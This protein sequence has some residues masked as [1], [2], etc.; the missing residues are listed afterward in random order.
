ME[1][2]DSGRIPKALSPL[3][4]FG[5]E[6]MPSFGHEGL[7]WSHCTSHLSDYIYISWW[8]ITGLIS[9]SPSRCVCFSL[10]VCATDLG[11][12]SSLFADIPQPQ[13]ML[14]PT[15]A[16][17]TPTQSSPTDSK[18]SDPPSEPKAN[19]PP[20]EPN[21]SDQ[22]SEP[23]ANDPPSEPK[24]SDPPGETKAS[25]PPSESKASEVS[26]SHSSTRDLPD[27]EECLTT[28]VD[29]KAS[30]PITPNKEE[31]DKQQTQ[32][33]QDEVE[34]TEE[35]VALAE[36]EQA[37]VC[38]SSVPTL[39]SVTPVVSKEGTSR[40]VSRSSE[41]AEE[42]ARKEPEADPCL[43]ES[44]AGDD[45]VLE[46][47][48]ADEPVSESVEESVPVVSVSCSEDVSEEMTGPAT[49]H[50]PADADDGYFNGEEAYCEEAYCEEDQPNGE[51]L[52]QDLSIEDE[53]V[54]AEE[55]PL[56]DEDA[57]W[58]DRLVDGG[59]SVQ[60]TSALCDL[61]LRCDFFPVSVC[62]CVCVCV[63]LSTFCQV[64]HCLGKHVSLQPGTGKA[65]PLIWTI[66][67]VQL[68]SLV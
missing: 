29:E 44:L 16:S 19:D 61:L 52:P 10:S 3:F 60:T 57:L 32:Q 27:D 40:I 35:E 15:Q 50:V 23:N 33:Q 67:F 39:E 42:V 59:F 34:G 9:L 53:G 56:V 38:Q 41:H 65:A 48:T 20:S 30:S 2:V 49:E 47:S 62:V 22:L 26:L 5:E 6:G 43:A 1:V 51:E 18:A 31:E 36:G 66:Y 64:W 55:E 28:S 25:D 4:D 11:C 37:E 12:L 21:A 8:G 68:S 54:Y 7:A 24:A 45:E 13:S 14:Q 46:E 63:C 17:P 58:D